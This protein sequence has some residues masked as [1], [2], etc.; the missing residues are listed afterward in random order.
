MVTDLLLDPSDRLSEAP[1]V[2]LSVPF[3]ADLRN[4]ENGE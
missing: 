4:S 3:T 1:P 2:A